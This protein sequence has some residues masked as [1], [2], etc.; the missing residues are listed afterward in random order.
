MTL[1]T[2]TSAAIHEVE[3]LRFKVNGKEY[4]IGVKQVR[5]I[6]KIDRISAVPNSKSGISGIALVRGDV[7]TVVDLKYVLEKCYAVDCS[8]GMTLLCELEE[9]K[10]AFLVDEVL[11]IH[12]VK[13][14]E[15][16]PPDRILNTELISGN[17]NLENSIVMMLDIEKIISD[18]IAC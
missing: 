3:L 17:I 2:N 15:V 12:R 10:V 1:E 5:E 13:A 9:T 8:S 6:L 11:G 18:C 14:S 4:A 7:V 16:I